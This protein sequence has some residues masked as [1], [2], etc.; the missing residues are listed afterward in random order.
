MLNS[1][2][3]VA[4]F[5]TISIEEINKNV[6]KYVIMLLNTKN[7]NNTH[8]YEIMKVSPEK[9]PKLKEEKIYVL[10]AQKKY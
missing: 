9:L 4:R 1:Q 7:F 2:K 10:A 6:Q 8:R 5:L 3:L